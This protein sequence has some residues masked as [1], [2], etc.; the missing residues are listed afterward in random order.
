MVAIE[1]SEVRDHHDILA[2]AV[3]PP[4]KRKHAIFIVHM[5]D[6]KALTTQASMTPSQPEEFPDKPQ[7]VQAR[8][9]AGFHTRPVEQEVPVQLEIVR[10]LLLLEEFLP[11]E[12]HGNARRCKTDARRDAGAA[13]A[14]P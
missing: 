4:M 11:H 3:G 10:P 9:V 12:K 14:I 13:P 1:D 6:A 5:H 2:F 7:V 8:L